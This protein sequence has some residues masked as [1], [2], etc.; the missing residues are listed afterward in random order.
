MLAD[1][2]SSGA[3]A[4]S[5]LRQGEEFDLAILDMQMP[6]MDGLT[7]ATQ[8]RQQPRCQELPLVMLT[9][10]GRQ[11]AEIHAAKINF[12]AFVNKPIKQSQLYNIL[13]QV[14]GGKPLKLTQPR[15]TVK[16]DPGLAQRQPLR[17]LLAEDNVVNQKVALHLL[18]R[19]GYRADVAGNGLEVLEALHRQCYDVVLMDVQMPEMD[20]LVT[21][22]RIHQSLPSAQRPWIIALTANAMQ[23]DR[24]ECVNAGMDDYIS[25]PIRV[26]ELTQALSR[27]QPVKRQASGLNPV[28]PIPPQADIAVLDTKA[29]QELREMAGED[30]AEVLVEV[31]D[32]YLEDTPKLMQKVEEAVVQGD[33][34]ALQ[35]AAHTLKSTS[36]TLGANTLSEL[37]RNLETIGRTGTTAEA[38]ILVPQIA[39]EYKSVKAALQLERQRS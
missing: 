13:I 36:A 18:Q 16:I 15:Y 29:L 7:L 19:M 31:I 26:E 39:V 37:C 28:F 5:L 6:E 24:E 38:T 34:I 21:T 23:G 2:V 8:I 10:V 25:K 17:I 35:Q 32:S 27:C 12:A 9:S 3:E 1:T 22:R 30:A 4:L 20:G 14:F 11:H 33:A